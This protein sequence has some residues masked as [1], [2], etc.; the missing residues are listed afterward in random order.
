LPS[1]RNHVE[2]FLVGALGKNKIVG[3]FGVLIENEIQVAQNLEDLP[4]FLIIA[5]HL[6][7]ELHKP[8]LR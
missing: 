3:H 7:A 5:L 1:L 4:N 2:P 8:N 6:L